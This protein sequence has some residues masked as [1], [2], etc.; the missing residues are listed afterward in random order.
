MSAA[1]DAHRP[2]SPGQRDR[3]SM[4]H[5]MA[6]L[7]ST[8]MTKIVMVGAVTMTSLRVAIT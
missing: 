8:A 3:R 4:R 6:A 2:R 1:L 7:M 5:A